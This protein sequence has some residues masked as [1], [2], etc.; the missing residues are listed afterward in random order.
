MKILK[1]GNTEIGKWWIGRKVTCDNCGQVMEIEK[2]D[3]NVN[4]HPFLVNANNS[5]IYFSCPCCKAHNE[6]Y[7]NNFQ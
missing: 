1:P 4:A 3:A 7:R 6:E 2:D 5:R